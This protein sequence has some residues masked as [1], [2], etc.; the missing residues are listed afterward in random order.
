ME[1]ISGGHLVQLSCSEQGQLE[2]VVQGHIQS[3]FEYLK[4]IKTFDCFKFKLSCLKKTKSVYLSS[5]AV[6]PYLNLNSA[7]DDSGQN[8]FDI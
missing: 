8:S 2:Q 7:Q 4:R 3:G 5:F 1:D 6:N